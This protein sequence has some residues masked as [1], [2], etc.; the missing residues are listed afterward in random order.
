MTWHRFLKSPFLPALILIFTSCFSVGQINYSITGDVRDLASKKVYLS[1][2][3]GEKIRPADS[4]TTDGKGNFIFSLKPTVS[5]GLYRISWGKDKYVDLVL[6]KENIVFYTTSE[7]PAD[8]IQILSSFEN[9]LYYWYERR[10]SLGQAKLELITPVVDYYPVKDAYYSR[11]ALEFESIQ[12][13]QEKVFDSLSQLYPQSYA[14]RI[15]KLQQTPFLSASLSKDERVEFLK[16]HFFDKVDFNDTLLLKSNAWSNK[17]ISYLGLW[18]S[19]R[20]SQKQL[21]TEFIKAVTIM[22]D[23]ASVN[24]DIYKFLLDYLLGGFDKY[25]MDDVITYM[26]DHFQDPYSCEDQ[27]KKT[28]LQKKLDTFKKIATGKIA[29]DI[30]IPDLKGK[31]IRLSEIPAEYTLVIFWSSECSHCIDMMP[32]V[33]DI[34][35]KQKPKRMEILAISIDTNRREWTGFIKDEKLDFLNAS[36]LKGFDGK[37]ADQYNIYATPTMFLLDREKKILAKPISYRELEQVLKENNLLN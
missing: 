4:T 33:R 13:S 19:S 20:F 18:G 37:P 2:Y 1:G 14:L 24:P 25:H 8:S 5:A 23:K 21:E 16:M 26:A 29:P 17:A 27:A 7:N 9:N 34:Y 22:M 36:D 10:E 31:M 30:T 28:A 35:D 6:N 15:L 12:R 11:S 3:Y 32:K